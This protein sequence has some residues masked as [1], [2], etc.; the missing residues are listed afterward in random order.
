M[1]PRTE[2]LADE[3]YGIPDIDSWNSLANLIEGIN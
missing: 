1:I 3:F 2:T